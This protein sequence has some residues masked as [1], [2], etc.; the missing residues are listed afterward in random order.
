[1]WPGRCAAS[2]SARVVLPVPWVPEMPILMGWARR[3]RS[4][5]GNQASLRGW[6]AR[7]RSGAA[8][9]GRWC[10]P[11]DYCLRSAAAGR[12]DARPAM[13]LAAGRSARR[14]PRLPNF[15]AF[16][17]RSRQPRSRQIKLLV[18]RRVARLNSANELSPL[19][20]SEKEVGAS[21]VLVVSDGHNPQ[22][23]SSDF[24]AFSSDAVGALSPGCSRF[25]ELIPPSC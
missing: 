5:D 16:A 8:G 17:L 23:V 4:R 20:C 2:A 14:R 21:R 3:G 22:N 12:T 25:H 6:C 7:R 24:H 18:C 1:M 15:S 11:V 9:G 13:V 19:F 10:S